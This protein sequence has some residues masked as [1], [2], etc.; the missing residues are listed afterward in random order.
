MYLQ[1][2]TTKN[3]YSTKKNRKVT[4]AFVSPPFNA[5]TPRLG[6]PTHMFYCKFIT[7]II[8]PSP[9]RHVCN[10]YTSRL[11]LPTYC[12]CIKKGDYPT[13][14]PPTTPAT[15]TNT[16]YVVPPFNFTQSN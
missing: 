11:P 16:L 7:Y 5:L 15:H 14:P 2:L 4:T 3:E 13:T 9:W 12:A 6:L 1:V 8:I 10:C